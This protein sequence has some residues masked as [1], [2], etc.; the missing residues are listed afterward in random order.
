MATCQEIEEHLAAYA[1]SECD[2]AQ[3]RVIDS[4]LE[5]CPVCQSRLV[6]QR[7]T[8]ELLLTRQAKLRGCAPD[9]LRRRCAAQ[10][11]IGSRRARL[12]PRTIV[13]L[14]LA[15]TIVLAAGVFMLFGW[16]SSVETYAA[17]LAVDHVKCTQFPPDSGPPDPI[18]FARNWEA[19]NGWSLRFTPVDQADRPTLVGI[20][21]CGSTKGRVAHI[22]YRWRGQPVSVYVLND[23]LDGS[24][25]AAHGHGHASIVKLGERALIWSDKARTYAVVAR[26]RTPDLDQ[27]A[28][29]V[30][31]TVE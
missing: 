20:R 6:A 9:N 5:R 27:V 16:G 13:R 2:A 3:R 29:Y 31:R 12:V 30:Q 22:F 24:P 25:E 10:R 17:Q 23:R 14:S 21:R 28:A 4:H 7:T 18:A 19:A 1:D 8:H 15:A 26:E 11:V